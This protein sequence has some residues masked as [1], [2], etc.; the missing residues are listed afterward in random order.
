M[1]IAKKCQ[2]DLKDFLSYELAPYP[3]SLFNE[4]GMRKGTKSALYSAFTP[5]PIDFELPTN[6]MVVADGGH[7]LHKV[8]WNRNVTFERICA[9][10]V[11]YIHQHYGHS[12]MVVFDGYP[13]DTGQST[14][15][16][17][18]ARRFKVNASADVIFD[19]TTVNSTPQEHLS[20]EQN[21]KRF[22]KLLQT[23]LE[24]SNITTKQAVEDADVL[25]VSTAKS[26]A[27]QYE[28]VVIVGEDVDLLILLAGTSPATDN[29][30][31]R[32]PGR[33]NSPVLFYSFTSLKYFPF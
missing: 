14:K 6:H 20:K 31:I 8:V 22:V 5:L 32:K 11:K 30:Y 21:K 19:K 7:L 10:Y 16:A 15:S 9:D 28:A 12:V 27:S 26:L 18:R 29:V 3:M 13:E 1:C 4:D 33:S 17:E 25:I 24:A 2:E 23:A